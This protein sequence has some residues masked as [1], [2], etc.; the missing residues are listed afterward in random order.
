MRPTTGTVSVKIDKKQRASFMTPTSYPEINE[1]LEKLLLGS[2]EVL[3]DNL[4]GVY[5]FGSLASGDFNEEI[6]DIDFVVVTNRDIPQDIQIQLGKINGQILAMNSKWSKRL[7]GSFLPLYMFKEL[8]P[9][10]AMHPSISTGGKYG[11]DHKGI[12]QSIQKFMLRE[13]GIV[14]VGPDP[15]TFI[16]PITSAELKEATL[17]ILQE[18]WKPQLSD[19]FRLKEREYQAYAVVTMCRMLYTL[20]NGKV[21][22]KPFAARWAKGAMGE[23]WDGLINRAMTSRENDGVDDLRETLEFIQW[24]IVRARAN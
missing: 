5:I 21:V 4:V 8:N 15:K 24:T 3:K 7:E 9:S 2:Q 22:S 1:V 20:E 17:E 16:D 23:R 10:H 13:D 12:E 14:L 11:L 6:S 19:S 18:W